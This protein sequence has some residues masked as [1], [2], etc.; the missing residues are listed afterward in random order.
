MK[1][2]N[3]AIQKFASGGALSDRQIRAVIST[4]TP[5]RDGDVVEPS[6]VDLTSFRK[7]PIFL[8]SHDATKPLG[9]AL[10]S[11]LPDRLEAIFTFAPKGISAVA[12]EFCGLAK[13]GILRSVSIGF[14]PLESKPINGGGWR[15]TRWELLEISLVSIPANPDALVVERSFRG[16]AGRVLSRANAAEIRAAANHLDAASTHLKS[17]MDHAADADGDDDGDGSDFELSYRA[18]RKNE[19][20]ARRLR[21]VDV[22]RLRAAGDLAILDDPERERRLRMIQV[23]A[24]AP[25]SLADPERARRLREA[26][27]LRLRAKTMDALDDPELARRLR[28]IR[29]KLRR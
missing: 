13:S 2:R 18:R 29:V 17:V 25:A 4:P 12:D 8:A 5:D 28:R 24:K 22:L 27:V 9:N 14:N 26:E 23:R 11:V 15:F 19:A 6:G 20:R 10:V 16:K 7:N 21:E 3:I 1:F